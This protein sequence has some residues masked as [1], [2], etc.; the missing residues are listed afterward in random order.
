MSNP[1]TERLE[2]ENQSRGAHIKNRDENYG[3]KKNG[4]WVEDEQNPVCSNLQ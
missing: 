2:E 1:H 4:E 3:D